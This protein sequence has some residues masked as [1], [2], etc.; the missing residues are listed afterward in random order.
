M[1]VPLAAGFQGFLIAALLPVNIYLGWYL[2]WNHPMVVL[3]PVCLNREGVTDFF[4]IDTLRG[5]VTEAFRQ[6]LPEAV[7]EDH[8]IRDGTVLVSWRNWWNGNAMHQASADTAF[9]IMYRIDKARAEQGLP[10][11]D[12]AYWDKYYDCELIESLTIAEPIR[13]RE[14]PTRLPPAP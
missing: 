2:L 6:I 14:L 12:F 11:A 9:K 8:F 3:Q 13:L 4:P 7:R 5:T 10:P 1:A